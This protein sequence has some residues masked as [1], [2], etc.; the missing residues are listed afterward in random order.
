MSP[1]LELLGYQASNVVRSRWLAGYAAFFL[2]ATDALLRFG[3]DANAAILSLVNVVLLVIPLVA[4]VFGVMFI[5]DAR[6]FTELLLAQPLSR[7][8]LFTGLYFGLTGPMAAAFAIGVGIPVVAHAGRDPHVRG[9]L[10]ALIGV[11]VVL[12]FVFTALAYLL[13]LRTDDRVRALGAAVG[14]WLLFAIV[15]DAGVL[16]AASMLADYPLE[17]P[18]LAAMLANPID[19]GRVLLLLR[20]DVAALLGYTGAVFKRFF[21]SAAGVAVAASALLLWTTVPAALA[22]RVFQ[23]K[24]F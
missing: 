3:G 7:R 21:G 24:N 10:L 23:R 18:L 11:G 12:T 2:L 1:G 15:Y 9:A 20:F 16:I 22:L 5:Y 13:A 8:A 19:L 6:E 4:T 17:K 14:T